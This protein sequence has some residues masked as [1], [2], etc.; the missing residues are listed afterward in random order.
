MRTTIVG[1]VVSE[2]ATSGKDAKRTFIRVRVSVSSPPTASARLV[3]R[4][5]CARSPLRV[6]A[7][8]SSFDPLKMAAR[9]STVLSMSPLSP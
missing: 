6:A 1:R 5:A 8:S 4:S 7:Q 2:S 9:S 3:H